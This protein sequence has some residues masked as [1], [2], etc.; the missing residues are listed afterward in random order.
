MK[1]QVVAMLIIFL[2][3]A[4]GEKKSNK[5]LQISG[6]IEGLKL[7]YLYIQHIKNGV[8]T[9][10]DTIKIDGDSHF[11]AEFDIKSPEMFY[12]ILYRGITSSI[13]D[14]IP[15]FAEPGK[16]TI[17]TKLD[18]FFSKA[19][20]KGSKNHA[21][22]EEFR[23][24]NAKYTGE[25]LSLMELKLNTIRY[26]KKVSLDSI[27]Q[28]EEKILKKKYLYAVN[29]AINN[30]DYEVAPYITLSE[31]NNVNLKYLDTIQKSM[32]PKV[33][34]SQ[35]GKQLIDFYNERKKRELN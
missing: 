9:N 34:K 27:A 5:N 22:Y 25:S 3:V 31:I 30:K 14:K 2:I 21:L 32:T 13:D 17:N 10:L 33:A 16:I 15:F 23:K 1:K 7:G 6:N 4:C 18:G 19:V 11:E 26:K 20:I 35:Y 8:Y 28:E 24:T 12:L 29:F